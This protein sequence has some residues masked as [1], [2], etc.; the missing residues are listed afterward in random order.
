[1]A[2]HSR[3]TLAV[4]A[5]P[6]Q[7]LLWT[8]WPGTA[9]RAL[10]WPAGVFAAALTVYLVEAPRTVT[11]GDSA[12]LT[13]AAATLGVPHP[14]GYP[15]Y[16]LVGRLFAAA[17]IGDVGFR[18]NA[19]SALFGALAAVLIFAIVLEL[20]KHRVS[21]LV[22]ALV[23]AFSYHFWS[24]SLVAEVYTLDAALLAGLLYALCVWKRTRDER[25]LYAAFLLFGLSMANRT[26]SLLFLPPLIVW[27]V[28]AGMHRYVPQLLRGVA[29]V[30]GALA[31]YVLL[32]AAD[33]AGADYI[34]TVGY[35]LEGQ[36]LHGDLTTLDGLRWYVSGE[37]FRPLAF[38][39]A[40]SDVWAEVRWYGT[41][42]FQEFLAV[43]LLLGALGVVR[44]LRQD[45]AF[46][47]LLLAIFAVQAAFFI[48]Y[49]AADKDQMLL[50]TALVWAVWIGLGAHELWLLV[51]RSPQ[52]AAIAPAALAVLLALPA[53][54]FALNA[55]RVNPSVE[56]SSVDRLLER[57]AP[58]AMIIGSWGK[59]ERLEYLR[60]VEGE[61]EDVRLVQW[62]PLGTYGLNRMI[63]ENIDERAVYLTDEHKGLASRYR[64]IERGDWFEVQRRT[65][66]GAP[67]Q[68]ER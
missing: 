39:Y 38:A 14:P 24:Q 16:V 7:A 36:P 2:G 18:L 4:A 53:A 58:D 33:V 57:A 26:T 10:A 34:W 62:W 20:T 22:A 56:T 15:L 25:L 49:A 27:G 60:V 30:A 44:L 40:P 55:V 11:D 13:T 65:R 42:L 47:L 3:D 9:V 59:I 48:N 51:E 31:L 68:P 66:S 6:R 19:M 50:P 5:E 8:T 1:M 29:C 12:E 37:I 23:L 64:L 28:S 63:D 35:D 41:W 32:P 43:G 52:R 67:V 46:G 17:P 54:L 21:A 45:R 61:R